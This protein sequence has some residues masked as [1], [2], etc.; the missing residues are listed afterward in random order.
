MSTRFNAKEIFAMG[1]EIE[2]NG[3]TFYETAAKKSAETSVREFFRELAAWESQHIAVFQKMMD[4]LPPSAGTADVFDPDGEA[5]MYLRAT[6]DSHVF[7]RNKDIAGL[8]AG[9]RTAVEILDVAITFEKDSIVFY[10]TMKK[11]V[12]E[13]L[14]QGTIDRLIDEELKHI[15][16]LTQ[17]R[18]KL[19]AKA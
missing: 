6:A 16:L 1:V 3:K 14:G 18:Q 13:N 9:C 2:A 8:V 15:S 17:R 5:E 4:E 19:A 12:A 10:T 7:I 11:V